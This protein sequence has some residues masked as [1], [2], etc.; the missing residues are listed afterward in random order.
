VWRAVSTICGVITHRAAKRQ[1]KL[2]KAGISAINLAVVALGLLF[3][4]AAYELS[5]PLGG[6]TTWSEVGLW[7]FAAP[8]MFISM[9]VLIRLGRVMSRRESLLDNGYEPIARLARRP[10]GEAELAALPAL[11]LFPVI[12]ATTKQL[13]DAGDGSAPV[14]WIVLFFSGVILTPVPLAALGA[15]S[16]IVVLGTVAA[17]LPWAALAVTDHLVAANVVGFVLAAAGWTWV[18]AMWSRRS[19][20]PRREVVVLM[21]VSK[22]GRTEVSWAVARVLGWGCLDAEYTPPTGVSKTSYAPTSMYDDPDVPWWDRLIRWID[23]R[24]SL[25]DTIARAGVISC[26]PLTRAERDFVRARR[27][28]VRVLYLQDP[29]ASIPEPPAPDEDIVTVPGGGTAI[30]IRDRVIAVLGFRAIHIT[31]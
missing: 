13:P 2:L 9:A 12:I 18:I 10:V 8:A 26:P 16:F 14:A 27:K 23:D 4:V 28:E 15:R 11:L 3:F 6:D 31:R 19:T 1:R 30:E 21:G 22:P 29:R 24:R 7:L 17:W 25:R 5:R 20:P